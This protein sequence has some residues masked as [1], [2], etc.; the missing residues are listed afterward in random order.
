MTKSSYQ[1]PPLIAH[2]IYKLDVGGLEN[3]LVNLINH[4]PAHGFR[5]VIICLTDFTDFAKRI[6]RSDVEIIALNKQPGQDWRWFIRLYTI[7]RQLRPCIFH[8]RNLATIEGHWVAWLAGVPVRIHG[9]HGWDMSDLGG[10]NKKYQW[11][12]RL[13]RP[14][15][16]FFIALS[17]ESKSYLIN[18]IKVKPTNIA[19]LCNGVDT[20]RF[21][22]GCQRSLYPK[23]FQGDDAFIIGTVGRLTPVKSQLCLLPVLAELIKKNN[24]HKIK[25]VIVGDGPERVALEQQAALLGVTEQLWI[26]GARQDV[27]EL[28]SGFDVFVLPSLAEG[29]SNTVLEAMAA[30]KPVIATN[31]GGNVELVVDQQT[32]VLVHPKN[33]QQLQAAMQ[34]YL[35]DPILCRRHG[36][37]ARQRVMDKFSLAVMVQRYLDIYQR[38]TV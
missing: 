36:E 28:L 17:E 34:D 26:T 2:L 11:L 32:G 29:I 21:T 10:I 9:E 7:L 30:G 18:K 14:F 33:Q 12:R 16:K 25:L 4:M 20:N 6:S 23:A 35:D 27:P 1:Q 15:V 19:L 22:P 13:T 31:V 3:G 5:H 37:A 38:L 8:T 24:H